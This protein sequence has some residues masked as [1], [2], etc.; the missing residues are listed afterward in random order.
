MIL[1]KTTLIVIG[2]AVALGAAVYYWDWK[3][4]QT[5]K[6]AEDTSK[7]AFSIPAADVRSLTLAGAAQAGQPA[8]R[9]EKRN[10]RWV[11][12]QPMEADA[13]E[14]AVESMVEE[15]VGANISQTEPGTPD[16]RKAYGL[17]PPQG[18]IEFELQNGAKHTIVL[19][20]RDFTD[21]NVYA[22][23]D[24]GSNVALLPG[25]LATR[26]GMSLQD[27]RDRRVVRWETEDVQR[28]EI[29]NAHGVIIASRKKD[30][31]DEWTLEAPKEQSGKAAKSWKITD[32][33]GG[34]RAEEVL[35]H[36]P[37]NLLGLVA[38]PAVTA[39]LTAKDGRQS[40]VRIS[41]ADGDFVYA[42][43]DNGAQLYKLRKQVLDNWNVKAAELLP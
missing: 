3:R 43:A 15:V 34:L 21:T 22:L 38:A 42:R 11:M 1:R 18:S 33:I 25:V 12:V 16:R 31:P 8:I 30:S 17:D 32:A 39:V 14:T 36:P 41:K 13:D 9:L 29:H 28:V 23:I 20:H 19:G 2:G 37:A 24:S 10:G 35:D 6:P 5:E 27:L 4:S 26:V 7:P 40:S